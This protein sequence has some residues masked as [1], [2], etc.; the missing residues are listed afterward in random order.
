MTKLDGSFQIDGPID[1]DQLP[2]PTTTKRG[3]VKETGAGSGELYL[4]VDDSWATPI[5]TASDITT[6]QVHAATSKDTPVDADELPLLDSIATFELKKLTWAN[7]KATLKTYFDAIY[8]AASHNQA[9]STINSGTL[10]AARIPSLPA[11]I[12]TSGTFDGNRLPVM[13]SAKLGGVPATG[14][15]SGKLLNDYGSWATSSVVLPFKTVGFT[16]GYDYVCD[17]VADDVQINAA[18]H[19][20]PSTG[21]CIYLGPG[22]FVLAASIDE[23]GHEG[24][25]IIGTPASIIDATAV[26]TGILIDSPNGGNFELRGFHIHQTSDDSDSFGIKILNTGEGYLGVIDHISVHGFNTQIGFMGVGSWPASSATGFH[27]IS[28]CVIGSYSEIG[29]QYGIYATRTISLEVVNNRIEGYETAGIHLGRCDSAHIVD[30]VIISVADA[31]SG[32]QPQF[33][34]HIVVNDADQMALDVHIVGN[35]IENTFDTAIKMEGTKPIY[36][37]FIRDNEING[38]N[39]G[40]MINPGSTASLCRQIHIINNDF[41]DWRHGNG[42]PIWV[43]SL[44]DYDISG[45]TIIA[46]A[47]ASSAY[48]IRVDSPTTSGG[49]VSRNTIDRAGLA[50]NEGIYIDADLVS[51]MGNQFPGSGTLNNAITLGAGSSYCAV[52]GNVGTM[53]AITNSGSNN[54]VPAGTNT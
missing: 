39:Y 16:A 44:Y 15:P 13:S 25:Q 52:I 37:I 26:N 17:G 40:I 8:A 32:G 41:S 22:T 2:A 29:R 7:I 35:A 14:T 5:G 48:S 21:G 9:A 46:A 27:V 54:I 28:N 42:R 45:N 31:F 47:A 50:Q 43:F 24:I 36:Q 6:A 38:F 53:G 4:R 3:A 33:G 11:S 30:N 51:V 23:T 49:S 12:I 20:M 10:D 34:I 18:I 1:G 19:A